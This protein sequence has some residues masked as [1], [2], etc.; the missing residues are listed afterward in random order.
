MQ[1]PE[2]LGFDTKA[3][4][5]CHTE[6]SQ[7]AFMLNSQLNDLQVQ[8]NHIVSELVVSGQCIHSLQVELLSQ[9]FIQMDA[10]LSSWEAKLGDK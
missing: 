2:I 1:R 4:Q 7:V 9:R 8:Y 10:Q 6:Q 5:K 3:L